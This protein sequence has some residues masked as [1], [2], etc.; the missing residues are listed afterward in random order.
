MTA[1]TPILGAPGRGGIAFA[2]HTG[3]EHTVPVVAGSSPI[4]ASCGCRLECGVTAIAAHCGTKSGAFDPDF[5]GLC[6]NDPE[7][8]EP[9]RRFQRV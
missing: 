5:W 1:V 4:R 8:S 9:L 7:V 3:G 6:R 2:R